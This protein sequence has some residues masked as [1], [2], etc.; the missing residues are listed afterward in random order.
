MGV[1]FGAEC[2]WF[3]DGICPQ[4]SHYPLSSLAHM[5]NTSSFL[6]A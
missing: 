6:G 5:L 4:V 2:H 3:I 1:G